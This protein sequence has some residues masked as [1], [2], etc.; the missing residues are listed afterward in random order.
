[1]SKK[2]LTEKLKYVTLASMGAFYLTE[3]KKGEN[4][5]FFNYFDTLPGTEEFPYNYKEDEY[6]LLKGSPFI[7]MLNV[8][9]G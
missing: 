4:S 5:F 8:T 7:E 9:Q 1:M 2:N 3:Y 6:F